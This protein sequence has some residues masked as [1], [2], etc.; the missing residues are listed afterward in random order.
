MAEMMEGADW[1]RAFI[2]ESNRIEGILRA[3]TTEEVAAVQ[4]ILALEVVGIE[5]VKRY[6]ARVQFGARL[7]DCVG[8]DVRVGSHHPP[9]GGRGVRDSL[10]ALLRQL[11]NTDPWRWHCD[12]E[13]LHPFTDGNGRSGRVLWAWAMNHQM[14][15][16]QSIGF[17]H[18]FYYQTL[19]AVGR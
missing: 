13:T 7:R 12:Y 6:V 5:D 15:P 19:G 1:L 16:W 11:P 10:K 9:P 8:L 17:L 14:R 18:K 4:E 2:T 3:P